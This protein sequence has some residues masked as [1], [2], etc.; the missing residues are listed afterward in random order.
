MVGAD[1]LQLTAKAGN[2]QVEAVV[3]GA[4]GHRLD[5]LRFY[6]VSDVTVTDARAAQPPVTTS[7]PVPGPVPGLIEA[8][9]ARYGLPGLTAS[10]D[11]EGGAWTC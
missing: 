6:L 1:A 4:P 5:V 7:G 8:T 2:L 3:E 10:G 9:Y 11:G